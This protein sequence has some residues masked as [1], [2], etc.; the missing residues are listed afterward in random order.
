MKKNNPKEDS[1]RSDNLIDGTPVMNVVFS[2]KRPTPKRAKKKLDEF[3]MEGLNDSDY[4]KKT[5][6]NMFEEPMML[7]VPENEA[8]EIINKSVPNIER[9]KNNTASFKNT[10]EDFLRQNISIRQIA[11]ITGVSRGRISKIISGSILKY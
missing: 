2:N 10:I 3:I 5:R 4:E 6:D 8:D 9:F 1:N 7:F 11:R